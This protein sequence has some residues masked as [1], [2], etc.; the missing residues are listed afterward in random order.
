MAMFINKI[1]VLLSIKKLAKLYFF[2][3]KLDKIY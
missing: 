2:L 3:I 1:N